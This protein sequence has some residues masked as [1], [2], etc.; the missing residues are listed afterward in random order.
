MLNDASERK[1]VV[2]G[3]LCQD[4]GIYRSAPRVYGRISRREGPLITT[5]VFLRSRQEVRRYASGG[6][7]LGG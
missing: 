1:V 4:F 5:D 7:L 3:E 6:G 2:R